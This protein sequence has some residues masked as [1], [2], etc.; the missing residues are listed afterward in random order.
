MCSVTLHVIQ[1]KVNSTRL[2]FYNCLIMWTEKHYETILE[3][4]VGLQH[5]RLST[6]GGQMDTGCELGWKRDWAKRF[7]VRWTGCGC[8][9]LCP[10]PS[11]PPSLFSRLHTYSLSWGAKCRLLSEIA[12]FE[13]P[14]AKKYDAFTQV[15]SNW[16]K[17]PNV[18]LS[19]C[20][21]FILV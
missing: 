20:H 9:W 17:S 11:C 1:S 10:L 16:I 5:K 19:T 4:D 6:S 15:R 8:G 7:M 12:S 3:Y 2:L 13:K 14:Y 18:H 21:L